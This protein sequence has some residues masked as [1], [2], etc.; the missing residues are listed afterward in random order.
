MSDQLPA[1][2][3]LYARAILELADHYDSGKLSR[4]DIC[5]DLQSH[6]HSLSKL[7]NK[8]GRTITTITEK[9]KEE[10]TK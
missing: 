1:M 9:L 5:D 10:E 2:L 8:F 3:R 4:R 7:A 6:V